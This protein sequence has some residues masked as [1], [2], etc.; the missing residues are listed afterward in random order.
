MRENARWLKIG[1][2]ETP[3]RWKETSFAGSSLVLL[4]LVRNAFPIHTCIR[5]RPLIYD[6]TSI[7]CSR[8][9]RAIMILIKLIS[10]LLECQSWLSTVSQ[11]GP[12][13]CIKAEWFPYIGDTSITCVRNAKHEEEHKFSTGMSLR[14]RGH[15]WWN[16]RDRFR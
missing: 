1:K 3:R 2:S 9:R 13:K 12:E 4:V 8:E 14:D 11:A 5:G 10:G 7:I 16:D 15:G 6:R